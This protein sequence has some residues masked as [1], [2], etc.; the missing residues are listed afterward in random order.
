MCVFVT[1]RTA[2]LYGDTLF[3][4]GIAEVLRSMPGMEV[5]EKQPQ[6][7]PA[8]AEIQPSVILLDAAQTSLTQMETLLRSFPSGQC[9]PLIRLSAESQL[10]TVLT[11][12]SLPAVEIADLRQ[13]L[14]KICHFLS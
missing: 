6:G 2:V 7:E 9:P 12:Q 14:E 10:L 13:A 4:H 3:L 8:F 11:A 5:I 1:H